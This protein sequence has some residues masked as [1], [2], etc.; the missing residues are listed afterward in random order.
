MCRSGTWDGSLADGSTATAWQRPDGRKTEVELVGL[1]EGLVGAPWAMHEGFA[2]A[3][4]GATLDPPSDLHATAEYR[5]H[6]AA[7]PATRAAQEAAAR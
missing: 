5:T 7:I 2:D 1:D 6:L 4:R 3:V